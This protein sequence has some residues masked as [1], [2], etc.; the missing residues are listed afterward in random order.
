MRTRL[1]IF[2]TMGKDP[3]PGRGDPRARGP[4]PHLPYLLLH[5]PHLTSH[6]Q[7]KQRARSR[8]CDILAPDPQQMLFFCL[9]LS[10]I[11]TKGHH[12]QR[13]LLTQVHRGLHT[14]SP[15]FLSL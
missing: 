15:A 1:E 12:Q 5:T 3:V 2:L 13:V 8:P 14:I 6:G 10:L 9:F 7:H 11:Q 4:M